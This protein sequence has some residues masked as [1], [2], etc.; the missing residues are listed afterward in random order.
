[1]F[2]V[3]SSQ[4]LSSRIFPLLTTHLLSIVPTLHTE[5]Q[6]EKHIEKNIHIEMTYAPSGYMYKENID[7]YGKDIYGGHILIEKTYK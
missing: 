3:Q 5:R 7:T 6:T 4:I 1:M 2:L